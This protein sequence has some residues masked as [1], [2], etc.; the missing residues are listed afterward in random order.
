MPSAD[1][2]IVVDNPA[3]S[4]Y[5][6][7]LGGETCGFADYRV[8]GD[9]VTLPHTVVDPAHRGQGLAAILI[10]HALD[11][12]VSAGRTVVPVCSYVAAYIERH[13]EYRAAIADTR[14]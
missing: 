2:P 6:L 5:E 11:D 12:I 13:P 3:L 7:H 4:R 1:A 8:E 10:R 9:V 14:T